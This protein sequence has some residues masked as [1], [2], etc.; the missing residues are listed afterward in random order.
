MYETV[1]VILERVRTLYSIDRFR[2]DVRKVLA[3]QMLSLFQRYP[4]LIVDLR[5]EL[6]EFVGTRRNVGDGREEFFVH[7]VWVIGEY[8]GPTLDPRC[9]NEIIDQYHEVLELFAYE[10]N[11]LVDDGGAA[12]GGQYSAVHTARLM[13]VLMFAL[14]KL[15]T[16]CQ[17]LI[18]RV[19]LCLTKI[20]KQHSKTSAD[21][22]GQHA[23]LERATQLV[24]TLQRPSVAAAVLAR[25]GTETTAA[26]LRHSD[27]TSS[28]AL[29]RFSA[30]GQ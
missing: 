21:V 7:V 10:I 9:T 25:S 3:E 15:A 24:R 14:S 28:L 17:D 2:A 30:V 18:P 26:D 5:K 16:R 8:A 20:I 27:P 1:S 23:V 6:L 22:Q 4:Q 13:T 19:A 12:D 11:A 29:L